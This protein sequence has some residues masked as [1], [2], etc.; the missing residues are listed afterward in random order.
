MTELTTA[1]ILDAFA[2]LTYLEEQLAEATGDEAEEIDAEINALLDPLAESASDK[3]DALAHVIDR[4]VA[5]AG[6]AHTHEQRAAARRRR[7]LK[8]ADRCRGLA[9]RL[10]TGA[11]EQGLAPRSKAGAPYLDTGRVRVSLRSGPESVRGPD[12]VGLWPAEWRRP[13]PDRP[14]KVAALRALKAMPEDERPEGFALA[15]STGL[16]IR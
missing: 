4:A 2:R 10:L 9:I 16:A 3:L 14:D 1:Q 11:A 7:A 13:Q 15:R 5:E 8:V 6:L 12:D